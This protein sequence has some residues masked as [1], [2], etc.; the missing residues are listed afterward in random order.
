MPTPSE[1][2]AIVHSYSNRIIDGRVF[3]KPKYPPKKLANALAT[4]A[5][6]VPTNRVLAILDSSLMGSGKDGILVSPS[7][8]YSHES[9]QSPQQIQLSDIQTVRV[10][11]NGVDIFVNGSKVL[12]PTMVEK[13]A[14]KLFVE[15]LCE[16]TGA[17]SSTNPAEKSPVQAL[18]DLKGLL[19]AGV[20]S[21]EEYQQKRQPYLDQL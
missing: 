16:I 9:F 12:N 1:I 6:G 13:D 11:D 19:D 5:E 7:V 21:E 15:M 2:E 18:K 4:Y 14:I 20:I 10:G 3:F 8:L 17:N